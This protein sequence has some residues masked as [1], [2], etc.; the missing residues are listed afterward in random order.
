MADKDAQEPKTTL[1][2]DVP[3]TLPSEDA[4]G[5]LN[6]A[7]RI[8]RAVRTTP[9]PQGLVISI[10][11]A[12]GSGKTSILNFIK[13]DLRYTEGGEN[14]VVIDFNPWW[15][16]D[17]NH[18]ATQF[19]SQ[20]QTKLPHE[21]KALRAIGDAMAEYSNAISKTVAVSTGHAWI[22]KP[23]GWLLR[24]LK[25]KPQDLPK[26]KQTISRKLEALGQRFVF[27]V[28]DVDRLTPDEMREV[29]KVI[30]ALADFPNV[31]YLL[32][33]DR[34]VVANALGRALGIDGAT[35]LEKIVQAPFSL[36]AVDRQL[37]RNK[38]VADLEIILS[39]QPKAK[40][41][42]KYWWNVYYDGL[43]DFIQKPRD[44]VRVINAL[45]V[46]LP[47]IAGE[48]NPVDHIAIEFLRIFVPTVYATIRDNREE[49]VG[50]PASRNTPAAN[51]TL[52]FHEGWLADVAID[53]RETCKRLVSRLF[54]KVKACWG[55]MGY[56]GEWNSIWRNELRICSD[57]LFDVFFQFG[58][59]SDVLSQS[60]LDS[61]L[62]LTADI[63]VL[64]ATLA[65]STTVIRAD[66]HSKARDYV[67]RLLDP[68]LP[69]TER[70]ARRLVEA[71]MDLGDSLLVVRDVQGKMLPLPNDWRLLFLVN[72][73][74]EELP[75]DQLS[76]TISGLVLNGRAIGL[77]VSLVAYVE[78]SSEKAEAQTPLSSVSEEALASLKTIA[79]GRLQAAN[80]E[81]LLR[82]E[83]FV[84]VVNSWGAWA[85][86]TSIKEKFAASLSPEHLP[87]LLERFVSTGSASSIDDRVARTTYS[88]NPKN[89]EPVADIAELEPSVVKMLDRQ[90]L[91]QLQRVAGER[92]LRGME[93]I[94]AGHDPSSPDFGV[95]R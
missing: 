80:V 89:M 22:D 12:W 38:L 11:G 13:H 57:A 5:Y 95:D 55:G 48:A 39:G 88:L 23:L 58:V 56:G 34:E 62:E 27:I 42:P 75:S 85:E 69:M 45:A 49:F 19:L 63:D 51:A 1:G 67:D 16:D 84:S 20:F 7:R 8:A 47:A 25:T 82:L 92:F 44:V 35:Y 28:D 77:A 74:L 76:E 79:V 18:L 6:F 41:D 50:T 32:S 65:K 64:K 61:L 66:G 86:S 83:N 43:D 14:P 40:L 90:D 26:L 21:N 60:E 46:T 93:R 52:A 33:F 71:V 24:L 94:R 70:M 37:L 15:F 2:S 30:K 73:L 4:Y 3:A 78:H 29:F 72:R 17:R 59:S 81:D 31:V 9:S 54:P 36:P 91:T 68:K 10:E 87:R 53:H